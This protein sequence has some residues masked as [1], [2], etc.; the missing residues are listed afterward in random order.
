MKRIDA[1]QLDI[2]SDTVAEAIVRT[3]KIKLKH[4]VSSAPVAL[5]A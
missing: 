4:V 2:N 5:G 1:L 3:P